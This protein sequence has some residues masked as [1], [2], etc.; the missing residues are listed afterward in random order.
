MKLRLLPVAISVIVSSAV[1]FGGWFAYH[2]VAMENPLVRIVQGIDGVEQSQIRIDGDIVL[3]ELKLKTTASLREIY[4]KIRS[5]G[6]SI[7][8]KREVELSVSNESSDIL[9]D[10]WSAALFE[11]AQS[12]ETKQYAQIPIILDKLSQQQSGLHVNAEM[13]ETNVYIRLTEGK[14]CKFIILPRTPMNLGVW[15]NE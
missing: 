9:E 14:N 2:S 5:E 11:V 12:M 8:G 4:G 6:E 3:V 10:W 1:L 13:D 7:I 15:P